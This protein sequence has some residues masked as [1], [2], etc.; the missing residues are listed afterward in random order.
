[1]DKCSLDIFALSQRQLLSAPHGIQGPQSEVRTFTLYYRL[2]LHSKSSLFF[3]SYKDN[4]RLSMQQIGVLLA[5][6]VAIAA[7]CFFGVG[8]QQT[9]VLGL[10]QPIVLLVYLHYAQ[11]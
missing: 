5:L 7:T 6:L 3:S 1:V 4:L 11:R 9:S 8:M 10:A 2:T